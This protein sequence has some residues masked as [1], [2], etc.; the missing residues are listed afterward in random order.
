MLYQLL[1]LLRKLW[2]S[3]PRPSSTSHQ[4]Q[5]DQLPSARAQTPRPRRGP[6]EPFGQPRWPLPHPQQLRLRHQ[7]ADLPFPPQQLQG[8]GR[9]QA[10]HDINID[11]D[12]DSPTSTDDTVYD[13]PPSTSPHCLHYSALFIANITTDDYHVQ[14]LRQSIHQ[15]L[16]TAHNSNLHLAGQTTEQWA[17]LSGMD[18]STFIDRTISAPQ[19]P[20]TT[21]DAYL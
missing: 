6:L 14:Q 19:R 15:I 3:R 8:A 7:L 18:V 11:F 9:P 1:V 17:F 20:G 4:R 12:D 2:R 5:R 10:Q 13:P 16:T 21:L